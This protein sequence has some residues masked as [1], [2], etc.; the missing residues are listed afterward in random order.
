MFWLKIIGTILK[1]LKDGA[2][3]AQ[4]ALGFVLGWAIGLTPGW[5]VQ[6]W[7]ILLLLLILQANLSMAIAAWLLAAAVGWLFDPLTDRLGAIILRADAL[8]ETFTAMY[9][10][11]PWALT[12]FNNTV[13]MG[14]FAASIVSAPVL[15]PLIILA[16]RWYRERLLARITKFRVVQMIMGSRLFA[17]YQRLQELGLV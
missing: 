7:A 2:T 6:V 17:F 13:V 10:L 1:T 9:N 14:A 16:V 5:P 3:P 8:Q 11:P 15:F 4:I 12:R